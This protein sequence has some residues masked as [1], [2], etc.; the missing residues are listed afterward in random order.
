MKRATLI[1]LAAILL[2]RTTAQVS[3]GLRGGLS[4]SNWRS[5]AGDK[6][7]YDNS[8]QSIG[9]AL[10]I[11]IEFQVTDHFALQPELAYTQKGASY[12]A[13]SLWGD[14]QRN[15]LR[16][17]Y[18]ELQVLGKVSVGQGPAHLNLFA[19]TS[20]GRGLLAVVR[21]KNDDG[22]A[23][24]YGADDFGPGNYEYRMFELSAVVGTGVTFGEGPFR[25]FF[26]LRYVHGL[27]PVNN[28]PIVYTDVNG[29]VL[30][31][32]TANI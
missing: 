1:A 11:P 30:G 31:S 8:Q 25:F 24:V 3:I 12:E 28:D 32:S 17:H 21:H 19:G 7:L 26:D 22:G 18:A 14:R 20:A 5:P 23:H 27:T 10:A 9:I 6:V 29:S 2:L 13:Y 15:I 16:M 4:A